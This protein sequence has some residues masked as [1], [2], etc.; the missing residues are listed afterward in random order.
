MLIPFY[1]WHI[2][3]NR[4]CSRCSII[5]DRG[6]IDRNGFYND[7][8]IM[9]MYI[10]IYTGNIGDVAPPNSL[11]PFNLRTV[12][13]FYNGANW[14]FFKRFLRWVPCGLAPLVSWSFIL[15]W[16]SWIS[17]E[18]KQTHMDMDQYLLIPF[19][20]GWTSIYQLF[21]CSP[22]VQGFDTL[23]YVCSH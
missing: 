20:G 22:G 19:L 4:W 15:S 9:G 5:L 16:L 12:W 18:K 1:N 13:W 21:W 11:S 23:P 8:Y 7:R 2:S 17:L 14:A 10:Y 6:F 3:W